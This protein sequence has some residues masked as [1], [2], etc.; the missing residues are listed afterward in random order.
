M[1]SIV[2]ILERVSRFLICSIHQGLPKYSLHQVSRQLLR[3]KI[4]L[5]CICCTSRSDLFQSRKGWNIWLTEVFRRIEKRMVHILCTRSDF[6]SRKGD[7]IWLTDR[8]NCIERRCREIELH[9]LQSR[10]DLFQSRKGCNIWLTVRRKE[11]NFLQTYFI[12]I[13]QSLRQYRN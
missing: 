11:N 3:E 12:R 4:D 7:S 5:E 1:C 2:I 13:P 9:M 6:E 10:S 8:K